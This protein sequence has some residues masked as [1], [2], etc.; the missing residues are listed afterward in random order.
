MA[1]LF[2]HHALIAETAF[3]LT[4]SMFD[5]GQGQRFPLLCVAIIFGVGMI[6]GLAG[7]ITN[8]TSSIYRHRKEM[9]LK[10]DMI[11]RGMTAEEIVK[12]IEAAPP[13]GG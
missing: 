13:T 3:G 9:D 8:M 10:R 7:I 1:A 2:C 12:V 5:V 11:D 4:D 6:L